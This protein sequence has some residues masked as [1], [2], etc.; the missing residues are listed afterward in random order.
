[1]AKPKVGFFSFTSCEGCQLAVISMADRLLEI[2]DVVD[3]VNFREASSHAGQ[4]YDIA[5]LEGAVSTM[6]EIEEIRKIREKAKIVI[7]IG[8]CAHIGGINVMKNFKNQHFIRKEV[9][10]EK[11]YNFDSI[12]AQPVDS[13]IKVDYYCRGCPINRQGEEFYETLCAILA[14]RKPDIPNFPVCLQCKMKENICT[15]HKVNPVACMGPV[16]RAGCD[17]ACPSEGNACEGCRG[18]VDEPNLAAHEKTLL[19]S[20]LDVPEILKFYRMYNGLMEVGK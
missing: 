19:E 2:V 9:Y 3:V 16:T 14:G 10:G 13:I 20:G 6:R 15:F 5:V 17:A 11:A 8:T 12:L 4:D 7:A 18:L 1:M